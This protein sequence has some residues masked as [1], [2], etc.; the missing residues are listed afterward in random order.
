MILFRKTLVPVLLLLLLVAPLS[1]K[2]FVGE[3]RFA[4]SDPAFMEKVFEDPAFGKAVFE[5]LIA[6]HENVAAM[7]QNLGFRAE[8]RPEF[9]RLAKV[10]EL[11]QEG[12]QKYLKQYADNHQL[13]R[14]ETDSAL[15][16]MIAEDQAQIT[17]N[18]R[19][20]LPQLFNTML[21]IA[22][23]GGQSTIVEITP[24]LNEKSDASNTAALFKMYTNFCKKMGWKVEVIRQSDT[25][26]AEST[27][28]A[29][30]V[31]GDLAYQH[32]FVEAGPHRMVVLGERD[33][34]QTHFVQMAVYAEPEGRPFVFNINDVHI[35][36]TQGHGPGGQHRNATQSA[37]RALH[38]P[39]GLEVFSQ[40]ER[41]QRR[42]LQVALDTLKERVFQDYQLKLRQ[43][44]EAQRAT[45]VNPLAN[46]RAVRSYDPRRNRDLHD[47]L[48]SGN[49]TGPI[50]EGQQR[51]L[52]MV[53]PSLTNS[54]RSQTSQVAGPQ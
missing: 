50:R 51:A 3:C 33:R 9:V 35:E 48:M 13:S 49:L 26:I 11:A 43:E 27:S 2:A 28:I 7:R 6:V 23:P 8:A 47:S 36:Y 25:N 45:G 52:L 24:A 44:L 30:R 34:L 14:S 4:I 15:L 18:L 1:G 46:T 39:T 19:A 31:K 54:I 41:E 37:V 40:K 16:K 32:L 38:T 21:E 42:N 17:A 53:L 12:V 20:N 10:D 22:F 5:F 29:F